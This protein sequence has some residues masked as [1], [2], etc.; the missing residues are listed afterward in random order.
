MARRSRG[1]ASCALSGIEALRGA[2]EDALERL[3]TQI[4]AEA[5]AKIAAAEKKL[6]SEKASSRR[7]EAVSRIVAGCARRFAGRVAPGTSICVKFVDGKVEI[8]Q[9]AAPR[10]AGGPRLTPRVGVPL[11]RPEEIREGTEA[12]MA[13]ECVHRYIGMG[14]TEGEAIKKCAHDFMAANPGRF[15]T[16]DTAVSSVWRAVKSRAA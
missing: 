7:R 6:A 10:S 16:T 9:A 8:V 13:A 15:K 1:L 3:K 11:R 14:I 12:R 4:M 5:Q 2:E